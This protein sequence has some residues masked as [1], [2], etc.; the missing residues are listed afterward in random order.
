MLAI[1]FPDS[2]FSK[3]LVTGYVD[4][5]FGHGTMPVEIVDLSMTSPTWCAPLH[6]FPISLFDA[7]GGLAFE[8]QPVICGG[9]Q[10]LSD[11]EG[12][13]YPCA[14]TAVHNLL[15]NSS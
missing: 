10:I 6:D 13:L 2:V 8:S 9:I 3:I 5:S 14:T 1:C 12:K 11:S 4:E 15:L 7:F